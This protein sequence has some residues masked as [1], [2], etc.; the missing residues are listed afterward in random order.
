MISMGTLD[1]RHEDGPEAESD[2]HQPEPVIFLQARY[3]IMIITKNRGHGEGG[4]RL[5]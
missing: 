5:I 3:K 4:L 2:R 1:S